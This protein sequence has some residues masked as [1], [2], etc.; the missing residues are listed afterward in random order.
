[1]I[2]I[3]LASRSGGNSRLEYLLSSLQNASCV[4]NYEV[5]IKFDDDDPDLDRL[6]SVVG[7]AREKGREKISLDTGESEGHA[8]GQNIRYIVTPRGLGYG[9]LHKAYLDLL[10]IASPKTDMYWVLSDDV[11][12]QGALW[13]KYLMNAT[14]S[15]A[16]GIYVIC[17]MFLQNYNSLSD[18]DAL[19]ICDNY[20]VW[21]AKL[22]AAMGGFGYTFSTDGWTNILLR[23]IFLLYG[24][25]RRIHIPQINLWRRTCEADGPGSERY[26]GIRKQTIDILLSPQV[27]ILLEGQARAIAGYIKG[28]P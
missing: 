2:T 3:L 23:K 6:K 8:S 11:L 28:Q 16:D 13:D 9:D 26:E 5:L 7:S 21:S 24:I 18:R 20:P 14:K 19:E 17:P 22:V 4:D 1:M 15:Y 10:V 12:I 27:Q 25:D